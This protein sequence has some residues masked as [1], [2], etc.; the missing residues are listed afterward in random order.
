MFFTLF[1]NHLGIKFHNLRLIFL[2]IFLCY[3]GEGQILRP[4][5]QS[6]FGRTLIFW[7][8]GASRRPLRFYLFPFYLFF[9]SEVFFLIK[10]GNQ[11]PFR[12]LDKTIYRVPAGFYACGAKAYHLSCLL[13]LPLPCFL[14][15]CM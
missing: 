14:P 3:V 2:D 9:L 8:G 12:R 4:K 10:K 6:H 7:T 11:S 15:S 5:M 13:C 1:A